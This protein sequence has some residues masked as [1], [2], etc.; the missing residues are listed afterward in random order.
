MNRR[1]A[2]LALVPLPTMATGKLTAPYPAVVSRCLAIRSAA[3]ARLHDKGGGGLQNT[4]RTK[5]TTLIHQHPV[6]W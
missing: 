5:D 4:R 3:T 2:K 6:L 1:L